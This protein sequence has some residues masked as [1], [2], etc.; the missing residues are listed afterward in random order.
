MTTRQHG[1]SR[2]VDSNQV[3]VFTRVLKG[4][5]NNR[6]LVATGITPHGSPRAPVRASTISFVHQSLPLNQAEHSMSEVTMGINVFAPDCASF[7]WRWWTVRIHDE[8]NS[9][10]LLPSDPRSPLVSSETTS[11]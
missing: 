11:G 2:K 1:R 9:G 10:P 8:R 5:F 4:N 7:R 3:D 6:A